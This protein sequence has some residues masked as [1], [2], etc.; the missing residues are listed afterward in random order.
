M[1]RYEK[2]GTQTLYYFVEAQSWEQHLLSVQSA[3]AKP[4]QRLVPV[5][6]KLQ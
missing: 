1:R 4:K 6:V 2:S 5:Y 3:S